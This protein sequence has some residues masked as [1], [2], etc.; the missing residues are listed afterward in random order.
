MP[1]G[2]GP[3]AR[4][5]RAA[6]S[7]VAQAARRR[8]AAA[9][10]TRTT[11]PTTRP[12]RRRR[13]RRPRAASRTRRAAA[14]PRWARAAARVRRKRRRATPRASRAADEL[15]RADELIAEIA[16][17]DGK[18][19]G[20]AVSGASSA[21]AAHSLFLVFVLFCRCNGKWQM[22]NGSTSAL[23]H[24]Q[25]HSP[26]GS[27]GAPATDRVG[28][29]IPVQCRCFQCDYGAFPPPSRE[30]NRLQ[31]AKVSYRARACAAS[32]G[33]PG[34][35][36]LLGP[37]SYLRSG[38]SDLTTP[39]ADGIG[40]YFHTPGLGALGEPSYTVELS[41]V[42]PAVPLSQVVGHPSIHPSRLSC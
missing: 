41:H 1:G 8:R 21:P 9:A 19:P 27:A 25:T 33:P 12:R 6:Q 35:Y 11:R 24:A 5:R 14:R 26:R 28:T 7:R 36:T 42:L 10:T 29:Q 18:E 30:K 13:P 37:G 34:P 31:A 2:S 17:D 4:A 38:A 22:G 40:S 32:H 20:S 3:P 39:F 16:R 23:T 15:A